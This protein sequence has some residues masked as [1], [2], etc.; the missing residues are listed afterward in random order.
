MSAIR[1][2][3]VFSSVLFPGVVLEPG[4]DVRFSVLMPGAVV[5]RGAA[6]RRA[7]VDANTVIAPGDE[8]GYRADRDRQRFHVMQNNVVVVGPN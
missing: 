2:A 3:C 4:A 1:D 6:V 7:V 8:I 5:G